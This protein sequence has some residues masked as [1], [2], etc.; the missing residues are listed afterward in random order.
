[1]TMITYDD[2]DKLFDY[3]EAEIRKIPY[4]NLAILQDAVNREME[5]RENARI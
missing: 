4:G 1:M 2:I 5:R 3:L